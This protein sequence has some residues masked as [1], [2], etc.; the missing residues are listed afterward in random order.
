MF[1]TPKNAWGWVTAQWH[2]VYDQ[3]DAASVRAQFDRVIDALAEKLPTIAEYRDSARAAGLAFTAF[4]K[5]IWRQFWFN[6]PQE[7]PN[8]EI[9]RRTDIVGIFP[10]RNAL[11][12]SSGFCFAWPM[13]LAG[14]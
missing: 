4:P 11:F 2:S 9:R 3:P 13:A 1:V 5:A 6:Y 8:R 12:R 7:R 14:R 10:D